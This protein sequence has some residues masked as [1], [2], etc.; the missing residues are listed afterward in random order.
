MVVTEPIPDRLAALG[1]TGGELISRLALHDQLL[2]DDPRR[3]HRVRG[4][5]RRGRLRR[6][7]RRD[8]QRRPPRRRRGWS[9][10]SPPLPDAR[11]TSA[12]RMPGVDR[13]T[14]PPIASRRS[15][16]GTA[17][18]VHYAHGFAGNGVGPARLAGRILAALRR[19]SATTRWRASRSSAAGSGSCRPSRSVHRGAAH[20]RGADPAATTRWTPGDARGCSPG[21]WPASRACS[22]IGSSTERRNR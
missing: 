4:G 19:R 17:V 3:A 1:W 21:S 18:A 7:H 14:S 16:R 5:G 12:S 8:L 13:S 22:D 15:A 9:P 6:A 20:P 11:A 2:P 10:T